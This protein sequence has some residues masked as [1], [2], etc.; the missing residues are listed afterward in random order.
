MVFSNQQCMHREEQR[1]TYLVELIQL[2]HR[3]Q[4]DVSYNQQFTF[5]LVT[6]II[7]VTHSLT[8]ALDWLRVVAISTI[9]GPGLRTDRH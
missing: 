5:N 8:A 9:S 6:H 1:A 4:N 7:S 3:K 2:R